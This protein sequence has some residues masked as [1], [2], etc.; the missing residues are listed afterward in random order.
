[1]LHLNSVTHCGKMHSN[2]HH[3]ANL[4]KKTNLNPALWLQQLLDGSA[5]Q[6]LVNGNIDNVF[7]L[8][9]EEQFIDQVQ[10][11]RQ[12]LLQMISS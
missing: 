5:T 10:K 3:T 6:V 8:L 7:V 2:S 11:W 1:M 9:R 12:Y 4:K